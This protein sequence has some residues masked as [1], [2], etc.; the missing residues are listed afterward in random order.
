MTLAVLCPGQGGQHAGMFTRLRGHAAAEQV[1]ECLADVLGAGWAELPNDPQALFLNRHAQPL[2]CVAQYACWQALGDVLHEAVAVAGYSAG[3]VTAHACA[4]LLD[5][6]ALA[7]VAHGRAALMDRLARPGGLLAVRGL[8]RGDIE[9]A[10]ARH[11]AS[12]AIVNGEDAFVVGAALPALHALADQVQ[13][14]GAQVTP[15]KVGVPSHTPLL[16][17]AVAPFAE[18]LHGTLRGALQKTVIAGIDADRVANTAAAIETLSRQ[19]A[20]TIEWAR[21]MDTLYERGCRVFIELGPGSALS[22]LI[23]A[24]HADVRARSIDDFQTL[25]GARAWLAREVDALR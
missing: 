9:Q 11:G 7:S 14:A 2:L 23:V 4:G 3:E 20:Q 12:V 8:R 15:L 16:R 13:Q 19:L 18:L 17:D 25:A 10:C 24:R 21:C 6:P 5:A 22:R 1:L